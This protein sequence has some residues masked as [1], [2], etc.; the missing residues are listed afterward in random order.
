MIQAVTTPAALLGLPRTIHPGHPAV[1]VG[2][3]EGWQVER[4]WRDS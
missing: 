1:L 4:V 2:W 3:S